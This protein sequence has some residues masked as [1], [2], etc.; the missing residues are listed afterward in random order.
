MFRASFWSTNYRK[1]GYIAFEKI[2]QDR[3][4]GTS[5]YDIAYELNIHHQTV[6][7]HLQKTGFNTTLDV[8]VPHELSVKKKMDR[9]DICD[10]LLKCNEI[11]P[12]LKRIITGD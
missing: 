12:F 9:L 1:K 2:K 11:E 3:H 10:M 8:W 7:N 5:G 6:S 4:T